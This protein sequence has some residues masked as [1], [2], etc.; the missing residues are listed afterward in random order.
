MAKAP[1]LSVKDLAEAIGSLYGKTNED[2]VKLRL[3]LAIV[4]RLDGIEKAL[5]E[6]A[7]CV[8]PKGAIRE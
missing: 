3:L 7:D 6:V 5:E 8:W 4:D 2:L 1:G